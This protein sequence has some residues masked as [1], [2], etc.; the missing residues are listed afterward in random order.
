MY[1]NWLI[2]NPVF[3]NIDLK[4]TK[5]NIADIIQR[6]KYI[7]TLQTGMS[8]M[9]QV[10]KDN[11]TRCNLVVKRINKQDLT[12][13]TY[14]R[15]VREIY[16]LKILDHPYIMK[17]LQ[18]M[19]TNTEVI[20]FFKYYK[21]GDLLTYLWE[22]D[23][24][25]FD[26][27]T[28][29][30]YIVQLLQTCKYLSLNN[31]IHRDIKCENILLSDDYEHIIL[32]DF[33]FASSF[34]T[35]CYA[36]VGTMGYS[37]PEVFNKTGQYDNKIDIFSCG[38]TYY[39]MLIGKLPFGNNDDTI[40]DNMQHG[41]NL[42]DFINLDNIDN[43]Y[44]AILSGML[45]YTSNKRF[46][47]DKCLSFDIFNKYI[48]NDNYSYNHNISKMI[49]LINNEVYVKPG[50]N[51]NELYSNSSDRSNPNNNSKSKP[52]NSS[53]RSNPNN[54]SKS[55]P[56]NNK[57][58]SFELTIRIESSSSSSSSTTNNDL[59]NVDKIS[60]DINIRISPRA[61]FSNFIRKFSPRKNKV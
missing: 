11:V 8:N 60:T 24:Q 61:K 16:L 31:I 29:N 10:V 15:L 19:E 35:S 58:S 18:L 47:I 56:I 37:A 17:I 6:Y 55:K 5:C 28:S 57:S 30:K 4:M 39:V 27:D 50:S 34:N 41:L 40:L 38:V 13:L 44:L 45:E 48:I 23:D 59:D 25:H 49:D 36:A 14:L 46:S 7:K 43:I 2:D 3:Q 54:N 1:Q 42:Y 9:V 22:Q 26:V 51:K 20:L 32:T 52:I 21:N 53:D 12:E 33:G